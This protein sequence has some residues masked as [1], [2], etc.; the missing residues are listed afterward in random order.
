MDTQTLLT[1]QRDYFQT[2][3]TLPLS[4]RLQMLA[5]LKEAVL[6]YEERIY[7]ALAQ[8]LGKSRTESYMAEVGM[9]LSEISYMQR[10]VRRFMRARRAPTPLAQF[11]AHSFTV[12]VPYGCV[13]VMSPW[14]YPFMLSVDPVADAL[15]AGNTVLLKPS[16]YSPATSEVLR[17]MFAEFFPPEVVAVVTGGRAVNADLLEQR[18]D[19]IFFTG[20]K[21]VGRL[22]M[23]KAARHLTPVTLELGGKSPCIVDSSADIPMAA[24]RIVFGKFLNAGQT[25]VAPD[26][27][28]VER[29]VR[30]ALTDALTREIA[31]Q[32]GPDSLSNPDYGRIVNRKHF[33]RLMGLMADQPLICGGQADPERLMIAPTVLLA[34]GDSPA[35]QEEI[36]GPILPVLSFER[37]EQVRPIIARNPTP[38]ALYLFSKDKGH[39]REALRAIRFGG[40]CINDTII[41]LATSAMPFGG[42]GESGMGG[43]H[44][45]AGFDAFSHRK[46]IVHK[47]VWLDLPM[48]YQ[49]YTPGKEKTIRAFLK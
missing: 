46:S 16:A 9:V 1:R 8:D 33:D 15:A 10:H 22:V 47:G 6:A 41:H 18:F 2:D 25:C 32:F 44:G 31:A 40:G 4:W 11:P 39:Q 43:Y 26:Y 7:E 49:P 38:L 45:R 24:R 17:A 28:L 23:E 34:D 37:F 12:P 27:I 42:T 20:G 5:R 48:R 35:M 14:N 13:L 19:N 29:S 36:F 30:Q 3:V 21:T